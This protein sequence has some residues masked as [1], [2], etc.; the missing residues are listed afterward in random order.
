MS[1]KKETIFSKNI[2][3]FRESGYANFMHFLDWEENRDE[4]KTLE[5]VKEEPKDKKVVLKKR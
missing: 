4:L 3:R 2:K 1:A 5:K